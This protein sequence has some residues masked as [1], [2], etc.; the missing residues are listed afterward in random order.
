MKIMQ[1]DLVAKGKVE[2]PIVTNKIFVRRR[3]YV[4]LRCMALNGIASDVF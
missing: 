2:S 1:K 3:G 4:A